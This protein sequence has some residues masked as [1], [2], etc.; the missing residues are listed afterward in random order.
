MPF[1]DLVH[2]YERKID[3]LRPEIEKAS[4]AWE[5]YQA[6]VDHIIQSVFNL[7]SE[8]E[9]ETSSDKAN[10][11]KVYKMKR[12][13]V[14]QFRSYFRLGKYNRWVMDKPF[15]YVG[16]FWI[17]D[18]I[19]KNQ[20]ETL[21]VERCL[22]NYFLKTGASVATRNRK[23][24]FKAYLQGVVAEKK[25]AEVRF[26]DLGA[27]PCR[28]V[29]ELLDPL[30]GAHIM[31]DCLDHDANALEYARRILQSLENSGQVH[32]IQKSAVRLALTKKI[33]SYLPGRYDAIFSTGLFDYLDER[34]AVPLIRN[35]RKTLKEGGLL[36]ISNYRDKWSNPSRH[37]M[38]W[39][40]DWELI[41][42]SEE[43]FLGIFK[44]AGFSRNALSLKFE[45]QK[46][47]QYCF[48]RS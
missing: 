31:I 22:D 35:L 12:L 7:C 17:I 23:E 2:S 8:F 42:R 14:R 21:G 10:E 29:K 11:E 25:G 27:G 39:G 16:D 33:E 47:M 30:N 19:Y 3:R 38:E 44:Q 32:F 36:M 4:E 45:P 28:D 40:G 20:P 46:I 48:A 34:V 15:G 1:L 6:E 9:R 41:Y 18:E 26:L 43:E 37:Y 24:D 5:R 13:F